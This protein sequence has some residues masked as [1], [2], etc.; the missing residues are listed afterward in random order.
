MAVLSSDLIRQGASTST[1]YTIDQSI[2]FNSPDE[3]LMY[4]PTPSGSKNFTTT[5]TISMWI[6]LGEV[7]QHYLMGAFYGN[8][9]RYNYVQIDSNGQLKESHRQGG[10]STSNGTGEVLYVTSQLFRDPAAWYHLI[11]VYDSTNT[12]QSERFR[13]YVN[14]ERVTD[15]STSPNA[16]LD[17]GELFYWFGKSSPTTLGA[18]SSTTGYD[19]YFY[20]DGYMAEIHG[21]D[22]SAYGPEYFGEFNSSNIWIPKEYTGSHG[23]D[24]FYIKG[25]DSSDLG[26]NSAANGND[27]TTNGLAAHDQVE[28]TPTNN[29]ITFNPLH[30]QRSGGNPN[31]GNLDYY[32][33]GTRTMIGTT[34]GP[35]PTSG[36]WAVAI[37]AAQVSTTVGWSYGLQQADDTDM[38]DAA[39]SNEDIGAGSNGA[40]MTP[41]SSDGYY[42]NYSTS[43]VTD[44][45]LP[46][47]TSDEF[48]LAVDIDSGKYWFGI[49]DASASGYKWVAAD[50]GLDGDPGAGTNE[51][52]SLTGLQNNTGNFE[53]I[54]SSK[55]SNQ[56]LYLQ[57]E[58]DLA[59]AVPTGFTYWENVKDLI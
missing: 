43:T 52:G 31:N 57:R 14:G 48:W 16:K 26:T 51:T 33:P 10:A 32:G 12:V 30:N 19:D 20:F 23:T 13:L 34:G 59:G 9:N 42:Y 17:S 5:A 28:D 36:K 29:K 40:N 49:Y 45:S 15:W 58:A 39:G 2:R 11:F 54:F 55:Q 44:P 50:A 27:F 6:K 24:G 47:T 53:F 56:V 37:K 21:V 7:S 3:H 1:G 41:Q 46:I 22:G 25:A 4:S 38:G 8:N 18:Y 35:F